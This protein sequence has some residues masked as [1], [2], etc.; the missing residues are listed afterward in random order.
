MYITFS[1]III[2]F[3][4]FYYLSDDKEPFHTQYY[5]RL[6]T[7]VCDH[8]RKS[9]EVNENMCGHCQVYEG[10]SETWLQ[11]PACCIWFHESGFLKHKVRL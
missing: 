5:P 4:E 3:L 7:V 6:N 2:C 10:D 9:D 8:E 1:V 11:C